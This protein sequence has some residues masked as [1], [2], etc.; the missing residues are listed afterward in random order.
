MWIK[1]TPFDPEKISKASSYE[2]TKIQSILKGFIIIYY[3]SWFFNSKSG[4]WVCKRLE[5]Y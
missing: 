4:Y 5:R 3:I 2:K 1:L